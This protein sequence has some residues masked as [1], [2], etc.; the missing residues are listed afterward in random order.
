M[1]DEFTETYEIQSVAGT[2]HI[3]ISGRFRLPFPIICAIS[4]YMRWQDEGVLLSVRKH[5]ETAVIIEVFTETRGRHLG[6]VRGGVSRKKTPFLQPGAQLALAW[7]ARLENHL[8]VFE[9]EPIRTRA[10]RLLDDRA[11]LAALNA[12]CALLASL[13]PER[14]PQPDL[15]APTIALFDA[16]ADSPDW[17]TIYAHWELALLEALGYGLD[18]S[19]CAVT[20]Q[21]QELIWVSP[22]TGRA[23]SRAAGEPYADRLLPLPDFLR[24]GDLAAREEIADAL[25]LSGHFLRKWA[26]A[27][28]GVDAAPPARGRLTALF[29]TETV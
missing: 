10:G 27:G 4:L 26:Y 6:L 25:K 2:L 18:L 3:A 8:G 1:Q 12:A 19:N 29:E 20:G 22:K 28:V 16:L 21:T 11:G 13:L 5:G 17:P 9:A 23:V 14:E 15:Y 24:F 7:S